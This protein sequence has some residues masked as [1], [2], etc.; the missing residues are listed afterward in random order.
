M[1]ANS[2]AMILSDPELVR[3]RDAWYERLAE[4]RR[5]GPPVRLAGIWGTGQADALNEPERWITQAIDSL[6]R[7]AHRIADPEVFRPLCVESGPYGVHF[8]DRIL[9]AEVFFQDGQ[10]W[11][12]ELT[13]PIGHLREPDLETD[14]TVAVARRLAEGF[15]NSGATVPVFGLPTIASPLNV[16]VN[17][18]GQRFLIALV[19]D[20]EA[21]EH[22]LAV[23]TRVQVALH[24]WYR[25]R[26][27]PAQVQPV[28]AAQRMLGP[29][30]GQLCGC[31][32]Q[33]VSARIY[34]AVIAPHDDEVLRAWPE[35][36]LIHLCGSHLQHLPAFA[37]MRHLAAVQLND[38]A[39]DD[40]ASYLA[41]LRDD[42][43]VYLNPSRTMPEER[44]RQIS[45]G[46]RLVLID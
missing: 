12:N 33:L 1:Y 5:G 43:V 44:A 13:S 37:E 46:R 17:L 15:L 35:P 7:E 19:D 42:Q 20:P 32:T 18:Y 39:A 4:V 2:S 16:A 24:R 30:R 25:E 31:T 40:L 29:G 28:I 9:G 11:S 23:I 45:G 6:A 38:R 34:R 22:D 27:P 36:G 10:W 14:P 21:A 26:L 41:G 8:L 3:Q